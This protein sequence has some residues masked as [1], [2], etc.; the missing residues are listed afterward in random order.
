MKIIGKYKIKRKT[1]EE[2][3]RENYQKI[4]V[5]SLKEQKCTIETKQQLL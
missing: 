4:L 3:V 2:N 1:K 5:K